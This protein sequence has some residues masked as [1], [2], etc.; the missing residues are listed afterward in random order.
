[1]EAAAEAAGAETAAEAESDLKIQSVSET[2][3]L[4]NPEPSGGCATEMS[5]DAGASLRE[6][7]RQGEKGTNFVDVIMRF[8]TATQWHLR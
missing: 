6:R 5:K 4:G 1:M 3:L 7:L 8:V 2:N